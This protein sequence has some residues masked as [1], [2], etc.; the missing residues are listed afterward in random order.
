MMF[1]QMTTIDS[2]ETSSIEMVPSPVVVTALV[3]MKSESRYE[4]WKW[5]GAHGDPSHSMQRLPGNEISY[6]TT[7]E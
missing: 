2:G 3:T 7:G 5:R 1:S 6:H 4:F